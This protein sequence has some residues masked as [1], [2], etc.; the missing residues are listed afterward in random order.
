VGAGIL[1]GAVLSTSSK[2]TE[3][4]EKDKN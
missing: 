2:T 1:T 4:N 3:N